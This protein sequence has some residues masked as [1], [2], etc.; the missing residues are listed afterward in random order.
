MTKPYYSI[1]YTLCRMI[2]GQRKLSEVTAWL[3]FEYFHP[4][5]FLIALIIWIEGGY[6]PVYGPE[7]HNNT[8]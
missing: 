4:M 8:K 2:V 6:S 7:K 5:W 3:I 1:H